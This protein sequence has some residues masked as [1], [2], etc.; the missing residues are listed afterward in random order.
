MSGEPEPA[1]GSAGTGGKPSHDIPPWTAEMP[2]VALNLLMVYGPRLDFGRTGM[3]KDG[4]APTKSADVFLG[5]TGTKLDPEAPI[6]EQ[7]VMIHRRHNEIVHS[8][9]E[10]RRRHDFLAIEVMALKA[11]LGAIIESR[12]FDFTRINDW[13][14]KCTDIDFRPR[15]AHK[16]KILLSGLPDSKP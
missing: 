4:T 12:D 11:V 14:E 1:Y 8:L 7:L 10:W 16:I 3:T 6:D 2:T 9:D 13:I 5:D 15:V